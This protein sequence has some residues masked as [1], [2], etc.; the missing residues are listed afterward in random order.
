MVPE[1][2]G[3]V[4]DELSVDANSIVGDLHPISGY[5]DDR[6]QERRATIGTA[7]SAHP[8]GAGKRQGC[9]FAR[10]AKLHEIRRGARTDDIQTAREGG[11]EVD[12]NAKQSERCI[13]EQKRQAQEEH[14]L[15]RPA[16]TE[17]KFVADNKSAE[18]VQRGE[19]PLHHPPPLVAAQ[20]GA[21]T[22][23]ACCRA[24]SVR[25]PLPSL[26]S[27]Y[28]PVWLNC[29]LLRLVRTSQCKPR[30][31]IRLIP[32]CQCFWRSGTGITTYCTTNGRR[33][34]KVFCC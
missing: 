18:P 2:S 9:G 23:A 21:P 14:R 12:A 25:I 19:Q 34:L 5:S 20:R 6:L 10:R 17:L 15:R 16:E 29:N 13:Q 28:E 27:S 24:P 3:A 1:S 11:R 7:A 32:L 22:E 4:R 30:L 8:V 26:W 33:S 31:P